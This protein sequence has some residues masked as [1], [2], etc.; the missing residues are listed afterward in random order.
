[1][2]ELL[3]VRHGQTEGNKKRLYQ[4]WTDTQLTEKGLQQAKR[5]ALR[6]K[7]RKFDYIYSSPLE[8]ALNTARAVNE[9][10][11][12]KIRTVDNIKEIHFGDWENLSG[13][14]LE[15]LYPDYIER[16]GKGCAT[17]SAPGGESLEAAYAR[18]NP[19][20][21]G[22]IKDN[23]KGNILVV[24]HA[25]AIRA[26]ISHLVGRGIEGHRNYMVKNC[27]ISTINVCDGFPVLTGLNDI[28][29]L[30]GMD[31]D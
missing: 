15:K 24:S 19:W 6:L 12:L 26:I 11:N 8:R 22:L 14:E 4:G 10:H 7:D 28:S 23:P 17:Y 31:G 1:M 29:H 9:Y 16:W 30:E 21:E 3:L 25:G 2:L 18:I 27:S 20:F 13:E 5:L